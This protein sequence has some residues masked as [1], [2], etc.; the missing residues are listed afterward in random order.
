[1]SAHLPQPDLIHTGITRRTALATLAGGLTVVFASSARAASAAYELTEFTLPKTVT[2]PTWGRGI[3]R[4]A[5]VVGMGTTKSGLIALRSAGGSVRDL[6]SANT[7]ALAYAINDAGRIVGSVDQRA[8]W[9]ESDSYTTLPELDSNPSTAF[10]IN[11]A[12]TIVGS[13]DSGANKS[14]AV[15]WENDKA[16]AL[17]GIGGSLARATGINEDGLIVG[18]ATEDDKGERVRAVLWQD[19]AVTSL[20]TLGGNASQATA[21]NRHGAVTGCAATDGEFGA[22]ETA[23]VWTDGEMHMLA[24]LG[25]V[26]ITGRST[27]ISLERSIGHAIADNGD[28]CGATMS[29]SE[30]GDISVATLW[31]NDQIIDLNTLIG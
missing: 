26:K 24:R 16:V 12:G 3:N 15:R 7:A 1:M 27:S 31:Q 2:G 30:N 23:F 9:W 11:K 19:G 8:A 5:M 13:S 17:P 22:V 18:Y 28:I 25:R 10:A 6:G 20:G 29:I 14:T 4:K 21:I